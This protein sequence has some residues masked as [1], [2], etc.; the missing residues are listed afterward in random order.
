MTYESL[1]TNGTSGTMNCMRTSSQS[2]EFSFSNA[3]SHLAEIANEVAYAGKRA[4]LTRKGKKLVAIVSIQDLEMLEA[5]EDHIDLE[6]ARK[7][8]ADVKK[9]GSVS[10]D[11]IKRKLD[12]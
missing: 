9:N 1:R 10:W 4:V 7:A 6:D 3:R 2:E 5:I 11:S 12:L 8:L